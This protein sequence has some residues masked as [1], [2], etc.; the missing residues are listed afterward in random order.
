MSLCNPRK[1]SQ[2]RAGKGEGEQPER[3]RSRKP[4]L[5]PRGPGPGITL[6]GFSFSMQNQEVFDPIQ[7]EEMQ[8]ILSF[9]R[10]DD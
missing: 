5:P 4:R 1:K 3:S 8:S 6:G 9:L 10:H 7:D 2:G